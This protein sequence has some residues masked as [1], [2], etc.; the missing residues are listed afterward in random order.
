MPWDIVAPITVII[1][2]ALALVLL[3]RRGVGTGMTNECSLGTSE[4]D[5]YGRMQSPGNRDH[6]QDSVERN[7][8]DVY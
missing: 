8:H 4:K 5:K 3:L 7:H 2:V 1:V 6:S